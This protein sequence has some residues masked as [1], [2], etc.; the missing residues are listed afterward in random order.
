MTEEG[1]Y[2]LEAL[3]ELPPAEEDDALLTTSTTE[4]SASDGVATQSALPMKEDEGEIGIEPPQP[5]PKKKR[6]G[7]TARP[8][9]QSVEE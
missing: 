8:Q 9:A 5:P 6:K 4:G 3:Q 2:L 1:L 7:K